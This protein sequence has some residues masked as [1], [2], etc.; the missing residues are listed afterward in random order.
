MMYQYIE[1]F[2]NLAARELKRRGKCG[3]RQCLET[4]EK[5]C[6]R[7]LEIAVIS[8]LGFLELKCIDCER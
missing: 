6:T 4:V 2:Y 3:R 8:S 7:V 1:F 5:R